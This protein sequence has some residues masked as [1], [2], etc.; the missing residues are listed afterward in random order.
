MFHVEA[1]G[2][3]VH[4]LA[5]FIGYTVLRAAEQTWESL[6]EW[7][8][9]QNTSK[10][11]GLNIVQKLITLRVLKQLLLLPTPPPPITST[12]TTTTTTTI[13]T[14]S[15]NTATAKYF[16]VILLIFLI[17]PHL[18]FACMPCLLQVTGHCVMFRFS[19]KGVYLRR[20]VGWLAE[21][22]PSQ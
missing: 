4:L 13:I 14:S 6:P 21:L 10:F 2:T 12:T 15:R 8:R 9:C 5:F 17:L 18:V 11:T 3:S 1:I 7:F 22:D 20:T 19:F 16:Y